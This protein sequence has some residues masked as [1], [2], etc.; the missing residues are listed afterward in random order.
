MSESS[1]PTPTHRGFT[2]L[3]LLVVIVIMALLAGLA[4]PRFARV[5]ERNAI[6]SAREQL[7]STVAAASSAARQRGTVAAVFLDGNVLSAVTISPTTGD[8]VWLLR[9]SN[10][11]TSTGVTLSADPVDAVIHFDSRGFAN[12][13][14]SDR[15]WHIALGEHR[16]SVCI[17]SLGHI[18]SRNC[19]Q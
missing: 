16:D 3:E 17:G 10:L 14:E 12:R 4:V 18:Y 15:V 5:R 13:T 1:Y 2:T 19:T 11:N 8:S 6:E 7:T 9:P